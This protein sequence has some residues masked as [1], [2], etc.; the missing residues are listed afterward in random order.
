MTNYHFQ[1]PLKNYKLGTAYGVVDEA[2]PNGHR[3]ADFNGVPEGTPLLA[4]CDSQVV[5]VLTSKMLGNI[6][7]LRVGSKFFAYCHM[8]KPTDLKIGQVI[9]AGTVVGK[10]G[11]TGTASSG[12]H[13][14]LVL[15]WDKFCAITG[16][17]ADPVKFIHDKIEEEKKAA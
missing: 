4:V 2:H 1:W 16:T 6:V 8:Q 12:P 3:G 9:K 10:L 7:V 5:N 13:L 11:N 14:H 17:V 15:G